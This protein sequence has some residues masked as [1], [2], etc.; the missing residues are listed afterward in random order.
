MKYYSIFIKNQPGYVALF[1]VIGLG[2]IGGVITF[3]LVMLGIS[4]TKSDLQ[5]MQ[6]TQA[7]QAATSCIEEALQKIRE[8]GTTTA[9]GSLT[10]AS[11][12]CAYVIASSSG[13]RI[14]T[15]TGTASETVSKIKVIV[16]TTTP[17]LQLSS[18]QDVP[19]F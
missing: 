11:S 8:T 2:V 7:R 15:A 16:S 4:L 9:L 13:Q 5:L 14:I 1:S 10:I 19:D 18:W 12:S 6:S 17:L 3:S